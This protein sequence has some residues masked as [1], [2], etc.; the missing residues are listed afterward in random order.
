MMNEPNRICVSGAAFVTGNKLQYSQLFRII[1]LLQLLF[2]ADSELS[3]NSDLILDVGRLELAMEARRMPTCN[4]SRGK[5]TTITE[6]DQTRQR[7][8]GRVQ[9]HVFI[10][11]ISSK[12]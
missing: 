3:K 1:S 10:T 9:V 11:V 7:G 2:A 4:C 8:D 6:M 12:T 5:M